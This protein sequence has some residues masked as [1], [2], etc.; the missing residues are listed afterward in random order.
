MVSK[1][2][3]V[4]TE[5]LRVQPMLKSSHQP[6]TLDPSS[7]VIG[8]ARTTVDSA[9]LGALQNA[10]IEVVTTV[11]ER[12]TGYPAQRHSAVTES[13]TATVSIVAEEIGG[14]VYDLLKK[15]VK[16]LE[17]NGTATTYP[18]VMEAPF[19]GGDNLQLSSTGIL[20]PELS[21]NWLDEWATV[22]F[23]FECVGDTIEQ[24]MRKSRAGG[25]RI[26]ATTKN[27]D[28]LSIGKPRIEI[29]GISVGS[30]Q[31]GQLTLQ[32]EIKKVIKGYPACT[33][34][35]LYLNSKYELT[36]S[37]EEAVIPLSDDCEVTLIQALVDGQCLKFK[38]KH[39]RVVEDIAID[40]KNDWLGY[41]RKILPWQKEG[42]PD[43]R[44]LEITKDF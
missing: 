7:L 3:Q 24:L 18:I 5:Q 25:Q 42:A 6:R 12:Y 10:S 38:F 29:G 28:N 44:L 31:Q 9:D 13:A 34:N 8:I 1:L 43:E 11:K 2:A 21:I 40:T 35:I 27:T 22:A 20:L 19:A 37:T 16:D 4:E 26:T 15:L 17:P 32:G 41:R 39:C 33:A 23:K 14:P 30:I 36:V